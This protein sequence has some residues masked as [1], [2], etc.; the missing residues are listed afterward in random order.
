MFVSPE[1]R[2]V[3]L[4]RETCANPAATDRTTTRVPVSTELRLIDLGNAVW[5]THPHNS[6]IATR[7]YRPPEVLLG[8][9][10]ALPSDM[11][12]VGCVLVELFTGDVLFQTRHNR[13]HLAMMERVLGQIPPAMA[14]RA[15]HT[16][17]KYF[18]EAGRIVFPAPGVQESTRYVDAMKPL[19][20]I[21]SREEY[22]DFFDLVAG[23][24]A[25]DPERRLTAAQALQH[26]FFAQPRRFPQP[27]QLQLQHT[28]APSVSPT[29]I[30]TSTSPAAFQLSG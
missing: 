1:F 4:S 16:A 20:Q 7:H 27:Q 23:L 24:L 29:T 12:S 11:F 30:T 2:V 15:S 14:R 3:P 17:I 21:I 6:V 22:P 28:V 25:Y 26:P 9:E 8:I 5:N 13:E 19:D 10:W 18:D